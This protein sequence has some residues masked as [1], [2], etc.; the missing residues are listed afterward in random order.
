MSRS[1]VLL[2]LLALFAFAALCRA[3]E[4]SAEEKKK[5]AAVDEEEKK[6]AEAAAKEMGA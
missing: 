1:R 3:Q 4:A 2:A 6:Q 5:A